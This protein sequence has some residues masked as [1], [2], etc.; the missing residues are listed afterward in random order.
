[1]IL[2]LVL[3][4]ACFLFL[5]FSIPKQTGQFNFGETYYGENFYRSLDLTLAAKSNYPSSA[6]EV[7]NNIG[8]RDGVTEQTFSFKV[9]LDGLIENGLLMKPAGRPP[10]GGYPTII[11]CHGYANPA[12]YAT[13]YG[14]LN[15]MRFYASQ[16]FAVF[17]PDYRGQGLT[18]RQGVATSGYYS[19]DYNTDVMSLIAA[20][21][22]TDFVDKSKINLWGHSLGA[23]IALRAAVLS[24]D[25][26]NV[27]LLSGP[28]DSLS[29]MY[30]RYIPPSDENNLNALKTRSRI[31]AKYGIPSDNN[32]FWK[33]ASPI[34]FLPQIKAYL[35]INV[36]LLDQTV[37][38]QFSANLDKA[39]SQRH[40]KHDYFAYQNGD[41]SLVAERPQ[42]WERS[43]KILKPEPAP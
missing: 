41:H 5:K 43:L 2:Y 38:P 10:A 8:T 42:I 12:R 18:A 16:G 3:F 11:L 37:P 24:P 27:V 32:R 20:L 4:A 33:N 17:K 22:K 34:N 40:I 13:L 7:V 15:D 19:M 29:K 21:K 39:L 14:Y 9:P 28:V 25:I 35:Q 1:L 26:K 6:V 23:Y 36:G 31:F 30:V